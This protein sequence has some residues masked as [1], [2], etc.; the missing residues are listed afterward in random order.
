[1]QYG[2]TLP[3]RGVLFGVTTP[4]EMLDMAQVADE[5]GLFD[6]VWVGDSLFAKPRMEAVT[7]LAGV[8]ARTR[9]V[10]L[11]P[12]C[13]A[14]FPLRDPVLFAYQWAS[15][16]L[17]AEGR[18]ILNVCTGLVGPAGAEEAAVFGATDQQRVRRMIE[19][20]EILRRLWSEDD[21]SVQGQ[22]RS[23]EHVTVAPKPA[24]SSCPIWISSNPRAAP[25]AP[26][27]VDQA[28]KRV[29]RRADGWMTVD[30][31]AGISAQR[32]ARIRQFG[33]ELGRDMSTFGSYLYHNLNIN[34][35][36]EAALAESKRFLDLYYGPIFPDAIVR[37]WTIAGSPERCVE[38]FRRL[39]GYGL[40]G[41]TVRFTAW[42]QREQFK[43]FIERVL[44][45]L[46]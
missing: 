29:A 10:R 39:G 12:G 3:N 37:D 21:V 7:L 14:S 36:R 16:D 25:E 31:P 9:R 6:S 4:A 8:A 27:Q 13:M 5:S 23:F 18:T 33:Q 24:Q 45:R 26:G 22:F 1:M 42:N 35:D 38:E 28:L 15:L 40:A 44:P 32:Y 41:V 2:L 34:P 19:N 30:F 43:Q 20:I 46:V 17:L 11:G